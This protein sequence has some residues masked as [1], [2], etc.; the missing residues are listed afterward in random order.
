MVSQFIYFLRLDI[1]KQ[2]PIKDTFISANDTTQNNVVDPIL[3]SIY[4]TSSLFNS[5]LL[6]G[7]LR[8]KTR[9]I[10]ELNDSLRDVRIAKND[11]KRLYDAGIQA[12]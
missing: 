12:T 5:L 10:V 4:C 3:S 2:K 1:L 8:C 7:Q 9:V 6:G 11:R